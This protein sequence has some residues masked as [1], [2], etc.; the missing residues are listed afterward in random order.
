MFHDAASGTQG[1]DVER[2]RTVFEQIAKITG[3]ALLPFDETAPQLLKA[4]LEAI[5]YYVVQGMRALQERS[6]SLPAARLLLEQMK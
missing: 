5:A 4:L 2:A 3:G 6:K 1:Y